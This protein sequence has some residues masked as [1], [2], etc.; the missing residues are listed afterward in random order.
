MA[1]DK[2]GYF[3]GHGKVDADRFNAKN[4]FFSRRSVLLAY[5]F[6][7]LKKIPILSTDI[8]IPH[9][10]TDEYTIGAGADEFKGG[11]PLS[12]RFFCKLAAPYQS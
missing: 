2:R 1:F 4:P 7:E 8:Q 12:R 11:D 6:Q 9:I 10:I 3:V 5:S